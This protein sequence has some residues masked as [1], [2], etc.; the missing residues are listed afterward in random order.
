MEVATAI[1]FAS[2]YI[3]EAIGPVYTEQANHRQEDSHAGTHRALHIEGIEL[4]H[5]VPGISTFCKH[6]SIDVGAVVQHKGIAHLHSE[7]IIGIAIVA[8]GSER[9]VVISTQSDG[10]GSIGAGVSAGTVTAHIEGLEG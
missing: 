4:L 9:T 6:Q 3:I 2:E 10:L 8:V 1:R 5:I 7:T